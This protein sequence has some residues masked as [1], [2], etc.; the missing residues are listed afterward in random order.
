[1]DPE[2]PAT[3]K[4]GAEINNA[5]EFPGKRDFIDQARHATAEEHEMTLGQAFKKYP[6]AIFWSIFLSTAVIMEGYDGDLI[7]SLFGLPSFVERYGSLQPDGTHSISAPWQT[8]LGQGIMIGQF[9][10]LF[11]TGWLTDLYGFK[12]T[13]GGACVA[14]SCFLFVVFFA[15]NIGTLLA[16]EVL[17]GL[18][19]GVF[20]ILTT[21]YATEI[22]PLALRP[23][24]TTYVNICW[25]I[26]KFLASA[27]LKGYVNDPTSWSYRV[28][29]AIQ[30]MWPPIIMIAALF[31]PESPW[32]FVRQD[33]PEDARRS[34]QR[35]STNA[36]AEDIDN[37]LAAMV[38]TNQHEKAIEDGTSYRDC[39][40]GSNLRRTE[41]ACMA[42]TMQP[43]VGF[44]LILYSTYF[45]QLNGIS[46]DDAF[47]LSLGQ[48]GVALVA[49]VAIWFLFP[50]VGRRTIY[51]WGLAGCVIVEFTIGGL[52][53]PEPRKATSWSTG[54]LI[55]VF[56]AVY[57][58]SIGPM[59]YILGFEVSST[60][61]RSKTAVLGRNAYHIGSV[62]NN[63]LTTYMINSSAW[64]WRGKTAFFWGGFSVLLW[65][66]VFFRLPEVKDRSFAELDIL[67]ESG[68][69][70]RDFKKTSVEVFAEEN[71]VQPKA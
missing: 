52:G 28:P 16:G 62:F 17:L 48:N 26:G 64:N 69:S 10:G 15:P 71:H 12:K 54:T 9:F 61:L 20:L 6:K 65:V 44:S 1:M 4:S 59:S 46:A 51:L 2:K 27:V 70:A 31:A 30:W 58:L 33:R 32:W 24:L 37:M 53:V 8:A 11:A 63:T 3:L 14:I 39:F 29:F 35:L 47:S 43:L 34:L 18:P 50:R 67:F 60:R 66:W 68:V 7:Y 56:Y 23:Y 5:S 36:S 38:L 49:G 13:I 45:F 55:I 41:I 19:L 40:K 22:S 57:S 42:Q 25:S 21:V